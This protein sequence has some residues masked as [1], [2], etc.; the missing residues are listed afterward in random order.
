M[1]KR[2]NLTLGCKR[3]LFWGYWVFVG[4]LGFTLT[5]TKITTNDLLYGSTIRILD[6]T[7]QKLLCANFRDHSLR[8]P[9]K[10]LSNKIFINF[11]FK[12]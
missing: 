11:W 9:Q 7:V 6:S 12:S 5:L 10:N 2:K 3:G 1:I 4:F 8:M